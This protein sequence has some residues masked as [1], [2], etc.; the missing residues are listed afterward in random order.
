MEK[1]TELPI[2]LASP[3]RR[4]IK[5]AGITSLKQLSTFSEQEIADLHGIGKNAL[6]SIDCEFDKY[7]TTFATRVDG[8]SYNQRSISGKYL[9]S[10][11]ID[12]YRRLLSNL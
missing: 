1:N 4:A 8:G 7:Q 5:N 2:K 11:S 12:L 6:Q 10:I 9:A 3:A